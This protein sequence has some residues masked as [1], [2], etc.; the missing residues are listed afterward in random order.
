MKILF[1]FSLLLLWA[2]ALFAQSPFYESK[3]V[4]I[5]VG[6][7]AGTTHDTWA[8]LAAQYMSKYIPGNPGFVVQS[9]TGAGSMV[10]ANYVY[11]IA[12]PDGLTL[13]TFNAALYFEQLIGRKEVQFDWPKMSWVGSSTPATRLFY[14]RADSPYA[15]IEDL[16]R[17]SDPP[18]CGT[19]GRGTTG[20]ILPKLF[21]ETLGLRLAIVSGYPGGGEVDLAIEKGEIQCNSTS[22][23]VFFGR[24]PFHSWRKKD[25]VR[26]LIQTGRKRDSRLPQVQTIFELMDQYKTAE[27]S[28]RLTAVFLDA[29]RFGSWPMVASPGVP[30]ERVKILREAFTKA[31]ADPAF[32]AE[33]KR[34]QLEVEPIRGEDLEVLAKEVINQSPQVIER[35]KELLG[36]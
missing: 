32:L 35:L 29:G 14:I 25:F 20:Y 12:K 6:Y 16:R 17:A 15:T 21:E 5:I 4:R 34:K 8:R 19:T 13:G 10:A 18:K 1:V 31:T 9:M 30:G 22:L 11:G 33:A 28:R 36:Q 7:P 26:V 23:S 2:P 27:A 3:T 24:E